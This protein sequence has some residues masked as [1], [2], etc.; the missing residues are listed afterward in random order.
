FSADSYAGYGLWR[1][2]DG[3]KSWGY[4]GF[5]TQ[6]HV[7]KILVDGENHTT[8]FAAIAGSDNLNDTIRGLYR[9]SDAGATWSQK[10]FISKSVSIVDVAMNPRNHLELAAF[11]MDRATY[12]GGPNTGI[13]YSSNGGDSWKR[14]DTI[15]VG[16]PNAAKDGYY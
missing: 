9:S 6:Q 1:S 7:A 3:G 15:N 2:L 16:L 10:L 11:A 5:G 13:W 4:L 8:V 14:I 12:S